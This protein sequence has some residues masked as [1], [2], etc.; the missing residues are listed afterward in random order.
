MIRMIKTVG[1]IIG[2]AALATTKIDYMEKHQQLLSNV[3]TQDRYASLMSRNWAR[4]VLESAG[5]TVTV[6]GNNTDNGQPVL[7][8]S[9]HEGNFDIPVLMYAIDKPFGFVS[10]V[11]VRKIP[12]L[13]R[14]MMLLNCI[15]LDRSNRRS[16]LQMIKDGVQSLQEGHSVM[17]FPEGSRS[18]GSGLQE[19]KSGSFKLAKS[20][21]VSIVPVAVSGTSKIM[22]Q[23]NSK[24]MVLGHV[25]VHLFDPISPDIFQQLPLQE[26]A[27]MVKSQIEDH[28]NEQHI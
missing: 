14:W 21:G 17:I 8:V 26:V 11:E 23:Y 19:F 18:K 25:H 22:E 13:H 10:K 5:V 15:Y 6:T 9:N 2:Y 7:F 20:A 24:R 27:D 3:S 28:L 1:V 16:S 12:F 4:R